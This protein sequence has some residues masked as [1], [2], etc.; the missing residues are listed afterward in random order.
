MLPV[1][2]P[3]YPSWNFPVYIST[4]NKLIYHRF[5]IEEFIAEIWGSMTIAIS[6]S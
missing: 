5:S 6:T 3:I 4:K 1:P 2:I